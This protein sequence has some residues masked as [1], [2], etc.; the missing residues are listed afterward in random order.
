[1]SDCRYALYFAP[2]PDTALAEFGRLWFDE[3]GSANFAELLRVPRRYGFHATLKAPF[4]LADGQ[5]AEQLEMALAEFVGQRE[6]VCAPPLQLSELGDFLALRPA[7]PCRSLDAL[8]ES[9]LRHFDHFRAPAGA[10]ELARRQVGLDGRELALLEAWG[11]PF[12]LDRYRFHM[13]LSDKANAENLQRLRSQAEP[14]VSEIA[15][16]PL[17]AESVCLFSQAAPDRPFALVRRFRFAGAG[18]S[19]A[20]NFA[21]IDLP[22]RITT[23]GSH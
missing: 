15:A 1:M 22:A 9:V 20:R 16:Q 12:V 5:T 13:T 6:P 8:A 18:L 19:S 2:E 7:E 3:V 23:P 17:R 10:D 21:S 4:R 11:Y 14:L